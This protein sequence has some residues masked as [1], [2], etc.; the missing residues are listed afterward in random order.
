MHCF[1]IE[2]IERATLNGCRWVDAFR[3]FN[4]DDVLVES[5]EV[6]RPN[7]SFTKFTSV[8]QEMNEVLGVHNARIIEIEHV[9]CIEPSHS[10]KPHINNASPYAIT[11][12]DIRSIRMISCNALAADILNLLN[13]NPD[14]IKD[15]DYTEFDIG[16]PEVSCVMWAKYDTHMNDFIVACG[17]AHEVLHISAEDHDIAV[18]YIRDIK[19]QKEAIEYSFGGET[20]TKHTWQIVKPIPCVAAPTAFFEK[21][22]LPEIPEMYFDNGFMIGGISYPPTPYPF[23]WTDDDT[24]PIAL[25]VM[26][27]WEIDYDEPPI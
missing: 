1:A 11:S 23:P 10:C 25:G 3:R 26:W 12:S 14:V 19:V 13:N 17:A 7:V 2:S 18:D 8:L 27:P 22:I 5:C 9:D 24:E 4:C 20:F 21:V 6:Q 15:E 16:T